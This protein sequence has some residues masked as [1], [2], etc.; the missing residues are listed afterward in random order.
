MTEKDSI[1]DTDDGK[2]TTIIIMLKHLLPGEQ[3][4]VSMDRIAI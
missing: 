4:M 1:Y 3:R 2:E